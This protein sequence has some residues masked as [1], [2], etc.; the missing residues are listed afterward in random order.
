MCGRQF[1]LSKD[2][3]FLDSGVSKFMCHKRHWFAKI[4]KAPIRSISLGDNTTVEFNSVG[5]VE[6]WVNYRGQ[7][8]PL[9]L[10][11]VLFVPILGAS[12]ITC[13]ALTENSS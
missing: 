11:K 10:R 13:E 12:L 8:T 6:M 3:I 7:R 4:K 9:K 1:F 5:E 2:K